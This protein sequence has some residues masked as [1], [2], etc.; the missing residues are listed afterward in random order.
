MIIR[1]HLGATPEKKTSDTSGKPYVK[2]RVAENY[3]PA[4]NRKALWFDVTASIP[5][6]EAD[7]LQTRAAVQ[8]EGRLEPEAYLS[9]KALGELPVPTTW[10]GVIALLKKQQALKVNMKVL[11]NKVEPY[12]FIRR[13]ASNGN[14]SEGSR[15]PG[16]DQPPL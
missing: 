1:G 12:Q 11:T 10:D 13:D 6:L 2:L 4:G 5:H 3:G 7:L 16:N 15:A 9:K 8:I 14:S